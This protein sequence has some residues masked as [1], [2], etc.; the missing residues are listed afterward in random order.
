MK[1]RIPAL[2]LAVMAICGGQ[3]F[4]DMPSWEKAELTIGSL[5]ARGDLHLKL[6]LGQLTGSPEF[7][8][9]IY[10]QHHLREEGTGTVRAVSEWDVPQ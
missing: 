5:S 1:A 9:P 6:P 7:S 3:L 2:V 10:L 8:F 4:A